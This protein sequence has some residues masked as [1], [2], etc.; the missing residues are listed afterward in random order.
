VAQGDRRPTDD[1]D[2]TGKQ[3]GW[4]PEISGL[5]WCYIAKLTALRRREQ[6]PGADFLPLCTAA[7]AK[8]R[9]H[10][11]SPAPMAAV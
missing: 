2:K 6:W 8:S 11:Y 4:H 1:G 10:C 3:A 5:N 7:P 9:Q